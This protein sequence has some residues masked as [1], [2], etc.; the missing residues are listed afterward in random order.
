MINNEFYYFLTLQ[1][2]GASFALPHY[3]IICNALDRVRVKSGKS[4]KAVYFDPLMWQF[5]HRKKKDFKAFM[6]RVKAVSP[7]DHEII[8][9]A[10]FRMKIFGII[11]LL[12]FFGL[13]A[14][15]IIQDH[16]TSSPVTPPK[17]L[18]QPHA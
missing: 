13:M 16:R 15:S 12:L 5:S 8:Q 1:L 7:G 9:R 11:F 14:I 10:A 6:E 2:L 4:E 17:S 3:I 18:E